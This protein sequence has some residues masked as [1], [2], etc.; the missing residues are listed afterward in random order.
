[1]TLPLLWNSLWMSAGTTVGSVLLGLICAVGLAG[2]TQKVR[3]AGLGLLVVGAAVPSFL[4]TDVWMELGGASGVLRRWFGFDVFT[5]T[6][7][8]GVMIL[9]H[10]PVAALLSAP[11]MLRVDVALWE[12]D[13]CIR[14]WE[15]VRHLV[16]AQARPVVGQSALGVFALAFNHFTVP[17]LLQVRTLPTS[18]WVDFN[19][20]FSYSDAALKTAPSL[21]L[22][23]LVAWALRP[24]LPS[25]WSGGEGRSRAAVRNALGEGAFRISGVVTVVMLCLSVGLPLGTLLFSR[26]TWVEL[27]RVLASSE[28]VLG[29]TFL[30]AAGAATLCVLLA[31]AMGGWRGGWVLW[32]GFWVPG[33]AIGVALIWLFNRPGLGWLYQSVLVV[34]MGF[35]VRYVGLAWMAVR[36]SRLAVP[37]ELVE[38]LRMCGANRWQILSRLMAPVTGRFWVGAWYVIYVLVL[39]D[40]EILTLVAPPGT[41]TLGLEVFNLLHYGHAGQVL[42]VCLILILV[43]AAPGLVGWLAGPVLRRVWSRHFED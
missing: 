34:M 30:L 37:R 16:W 22:F 19:T 40:V 31:V 43:A 29:N 9:I 14:R 17:A 38:D 26:A 6:G 5:R 7:A 24:R 1:M 13:L 11:S 23:G 10:W 25:F 36:G 35:L 39:W 41:Q 27:P 15:A 3:G 12:S 33:V 20:T 21:L 2:A 42:S 32:A 4:T 28:R 8:I 18:L